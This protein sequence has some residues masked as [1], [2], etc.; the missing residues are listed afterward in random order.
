MTFKNKTYLRIFLFKNKKKFG[1]IRNS[2]RK[3]QYLIHLLYVLHLTNVL[4]TNENI[5]LI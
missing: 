3:N 1:K 5:K 2:Y 4:L